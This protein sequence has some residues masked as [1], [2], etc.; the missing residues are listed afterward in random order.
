MQSPSGGCDPGV[1][2]IIYL[3]SKY[4]YLH[5]LQLT[6]CRVGNEQEDATLVENHRDCLRPGC[7]RQLPLGAGAGATLRRYERFQPGAVA[8]LRGEPG[9]RNT[10]PSYLRRRLGCAPPKRLVRKSGAPGLS[11]DA[12]LR[13]CDRHS[14]R[15]VLDIS[16]S[17]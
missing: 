11:R 7:G 10:R 14:C 13:T 12:D 3:S 4:F 8:L 16:A 2:Q 9:R 15:M 6:D 5:R 1:H 17:M